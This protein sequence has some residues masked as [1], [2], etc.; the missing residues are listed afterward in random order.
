M[1][2]THVGRATLLS[3]EV[4]ELYQT[5]PN[6][7]KLSLGL[8]PVGC[9][10]M[11]FL[12][13]KFMDCQWQF[14]QN[15]KPGQHDSLNVSI[16][17]HY[18]SV[19]NLSSI[20][21]EGLLSHTERVRNNINAKKPSA[22]FGDGIYT[23]NN[24]WCFQKYGD[25]G[26]L[27]ATLQGTSQRV[28]WN[29]GHLVDEKVCT[30]TNWNTSTGA[31]N[32]R[33]GNK[34][35]DHNEY[36]DE[37]V[38]QSSTQCLPLFRFSKCS[39]SPFDAESISNRLLWKLHADLQIVLDNFFHHSIVEKPQKIA[40]LKLQT[41][42]LEAQAAGLTMHHNPPPPPRRENQGLPSSLPTTYQGPPSHTHR[43]PPA[44]HYPESRGAQGP[45]LLP[46]GYGHH[47]QSW[48]VGYTKGTWTWRYWCS[49]GKASFRAT[50]SRTP[51]VATNRWS[52]WYTSKSSVGKGFA[53]GIHTSLR[54]RM[55]AIRPWWWSLWYTSKS[56]V[57]K[58]F[59]GGIHT[60]LRNPMV[61]TI[62]LWWWP[63]SVI[64]GFATDP[65]T[66]LLTSCLPIHT[67]CF[68]KVSVSFSVW[69]KISYFLSVRENEF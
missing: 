64:G 56:S 42:A 28:H 22:Y 57:G 49:I 39:I 12:A 61:E 48:N 36:Y 66:W 16:G 6:T 44:R 37:I 9:D 10:D 34:T 18:T 67:Y 65:L 60:F 30:V 17:Y 40:G 1:M 59:A 47:G 29:N 13:E 54:T 27:C 11:V 35:R 32:T 24:P 23:A 45:S 50:F 51:I 31:V 15:K 7:T 19:A 21:T 63:L 3:Q 41:K 8:E 14:A 69:K 4:L 55:V 52:L 58:G 20:R 26:L 43:P 2:L 33:I 53:G 68:L 62:I 25:V 5:L 46:G 38:L